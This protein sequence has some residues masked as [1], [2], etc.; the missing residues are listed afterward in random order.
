MTGQVLGAPLARQRFL[1]GE[2]EELIDEA[3]HLR[4]LPLDRVPVG[5]AGELRALQSQVENCEGRAQLMRGIRREPPL[6]G[7]GAREPI[8]GA[9]DGL[10]QRLDL[11]G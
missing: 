6:R 11:S 1:A 4:E 10:D 9:V 7:V 5:V 2:I 3:A 8:Q